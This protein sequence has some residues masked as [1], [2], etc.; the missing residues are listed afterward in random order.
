MNFKILCRNFEAPTQPYQIKQTESKSAKKWQRRSKFKHFESGRLAGR[1][2]THTYRA[3]FIVPSQTLF[4]GDNQKKL[5]SLKEGQ[6]FLNEDLTP[7]RAKLLKLVKESTEHKPFTMNTRVVVFDQ[8]KGKR[9]YIES[10]DDLFRVG[11]DVD[12]DT[13]KKLDLSRY[14]TIP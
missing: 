6:V 7:L 14:L 4:G 5:K 10:P 9:T 3:R 8:K 1:T 2:D 11:I 12:Q 13:L